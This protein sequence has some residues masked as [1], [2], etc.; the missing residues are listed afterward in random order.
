MA[1]SN[2]VSLKILDDWSCCCFPEIRIERRIDLFNAVLSE[3]V[4]PAKKVCVN[5]VGTFEESRALLIGLEVFGPC[6]SEGISGI[7][8]KSLLML[9]LKEKENF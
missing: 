7:L 6:T 2:G 5:D 1:F 8:N 3:F 4:A 9:N